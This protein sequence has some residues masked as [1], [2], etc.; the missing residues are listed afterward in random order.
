MENTTIIQHHHLNNREYEIQIY[1]L[2]GQVAYV[3]KW[4][5]VV[6]SHYQKVLFD[7]VSIDGNFK[8]RKPLF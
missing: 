5:T 4:L 3:E 7:S 8:S 2:S 1:S 6:L